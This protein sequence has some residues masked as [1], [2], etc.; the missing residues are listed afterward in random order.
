MYINII[1]S[2]ILRQLLSSFICAVWLLIY[3]RIYCFGELKIF[4]VLLFI[5]YEYVMYGLG[6]GSSDSLECIW[7]GLSNANTIVL[8][9][10]MH[11]MC[12]ELLPCNADTIA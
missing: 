1:S 11:S 2:Y 4:H 8:S 5:I 10:I 9:W 6:I 3:E 7:S 12:I